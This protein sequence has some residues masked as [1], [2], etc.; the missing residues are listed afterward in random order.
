MNLYSINQTFFSMNF[1]KLGGDKMSE[2]ADSLVFVSKKK[3]DLKRDS[4]QTPEFDADPM[5]KDNY[6]SFLEN[7]YDDVLNA[8]IR[9]KNST[10]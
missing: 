7:I 1:C 2:D 5:L 9:S 6:I 3:A 10:K 8:R 4:N